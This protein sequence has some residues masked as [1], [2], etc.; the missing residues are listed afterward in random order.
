MFGNLEGWVFSVVLV[1]AV[2][3]SLLL[4]SGPT[5]A[6]GATM[7]LSFLFPVWPKIVVSGIPI[8]VRTTVAVMNLLF[9]TLNPRRFHPRGKI[10]RPLTLLD[11]CVALICVTHI[12]L[13][14]NGILISTPASSLR[15]MGSA[16][17]SGAI[18]RKQPG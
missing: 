15:R 8:N 14:Y 13:F 17:C 11:F 4:R 1:V 9:F 6:L 12:G 18:R 2:W 7:V 16:V 5:A 3:I 10:L